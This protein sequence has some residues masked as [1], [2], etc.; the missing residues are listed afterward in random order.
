MDI[1]NSSQQQSQQS[2]YISEDNGHTMD[3]TSVI[4]HAVGNDSR[5]SLGRRVSFAPVSH[6]RFFSKNQGGS[7]SAASSPEAPRERPRD[8][9]PPVVND[10]NAY[11]GA[12]NKRRRS[13]N[14]RY[15]LA[16]SEADDMDLTGIGPAAF[17]IHRDGVADDDDDGEFGENDDEMEMTEVLQAQLARR[18]SVAIGSRQPLAP[19]STMTDDGEEDLDQ[20]GSYMEEDSTTRSDFEGDRS[21]IMDVTIPLAQSLK[22][23]NQ[24]E[25][26]LALKRMA[27]GGDTSLDGD[28]IGDEDNEA[29]DENNDGL[30]LEA[31][32]QRL[33][34]AR[35][36]LSLSQ[37]TLD[38]TDTPL[39]PQHV[40]MEAS[41]TSTDDSMMMD[42]ENMGMEGDRTLNMSKIVGRA[43]L[44]G[45]MGSRLSVGGMAEISM[46]E[47]EIYG[48]IM[49]TEIPHSSPISP[50]RPQSEELYSAASRMPIVEALPEIEQPT[51]NPLKSSI[52]HP[53][54]KEDGRNSATA[55]IQPAP[56][57]PN[58]VEG[59]V[60]KAPTS[61]VTTESSAIPVFSPPPAPTGVPNV[62]A[63]T[64]QPPANAPKPP[65][66]IPQPKSPFRSPQKSFKTL[67]K[68][69]A[70]T[71]FS[72]AFAPPVAKPTPTR[73]TSGSTASGSTNDSNASASSATARSG[74]ASTFS[75]NKRSRSEIESA[76]TD[77]LTPAKRAALSHSAAANVP[78]TVSRAKS[79][80][81]TK[82]FSRPSFSGMGL[83]SA[84][85][86]AAGRRASV[87]YAAR[88]KS[89][90]MGL[91]ASTSGKGPFTPSA[92]TDSMAG[93][94][95]GAVIAHETPSGPVESQI[96]LP[97][98]QP[99][100]SKTKRMAR[101]SI[102]PGSSHQAKLIPISESENPASQLTLTT[103]S[104]QAS[105]E[106]LPGTQS[107]A[108]SAGEVVVMLGT[109]PS[110][111]ETTTGQGDLQ[112]PSEQVDMPED[113]IDLGMTEE[114]ADME[115]TT[116]FLAK[117]QDQLPLSQPEHEQF[118]MSMSS[119]VQTTAAATNAMRFTSEA[120]AKRRQSLR[121]PI[122]QEE[123][124]EDAMDIHSAT[125]QWGDQVAHIK[126]VNTVAGN[127][128]DEEDD[129]VSYSGSVIWT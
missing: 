61:T 48:R 102:A 21:S 57:V 122:Q 96:T 115:M 124:E 106:S 75:S 26:W 56:T 17:A 23:A 3:F 84:N 94:D 29:Y 64:F 113:D 9:P 36:S 45:L 43:S 104:P 53:P 120:L 100:P 32:K 25:V 15:S 87:G 11:P 91:A 78:A 117:L 72:A 119:Q 85:P 67:H 27:G 55:T 123:L 4:N 74:T 60:F 5:K 47:S 66:L 116:D 8:D 7:S 129:I 105:Q 126:I 69:P 40:A 63:F 58:H 71:T 50:P 82:V 68:S 46:D 28:E 12:S 112:E 128:D 41:F 92:A 125:K 30:D 18:K 101:Q 90:G 77:R 38:D 99:S 76:D 95:S 109:P 97:P 54:P 6:V 19:I 110:S 127:E 86:T 98:P 59:P 103:A 83:T 52:F 107:S 16:T 51:S 65:S 93:G 39:V 62:S 14:I 121:K 37:E 89:I 44:G 33:L 88:R 79:P 20:S 35:E 118:A 114:E 34:R 49:P 22:P 31:A 42:D 111:Q 13:S 108:T 1:Q 2:S 81:R 70:K 10:E 80:T 73:S 24:D